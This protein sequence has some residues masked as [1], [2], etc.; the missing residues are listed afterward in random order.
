MANKKPLYIENGRIQ[1]F[2]AGDTISASIAPG[3]GGGGGGGGMSPFW[4]VE[5]TPPSAADFTT[6]K[7]GTVTGESFTDTSRGPLLAQNGGNGVRIMVAEQSKVLSGDW[8]VTGMVNI[9]NPIKN[10]VSIG[11]SIRDSSSGRIQ[12]LCQGEGFG[13]VV[14]NWNSV[15]SF[16][17]IPVSLANVGHRNPV[18][19]RISCVS[20]ALTYSLSFDGDNFYPVYVTTRGVWATSPDRIGLFMNAETLGAPFGKPSATLMSW[21]FENL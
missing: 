9:A 4:A 3:S 20:S 19:F 10:Y 5:P 11:V 8:Q 13:Y 14:M 21:L 15:S 18:S 12:A 16:S 2:G 17:S 1:E 7:N 6:I